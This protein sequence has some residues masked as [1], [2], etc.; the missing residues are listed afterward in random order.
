MKRGSKCGKWK[1][2]EESQRWGRGLNTGS[3]VC[4]LDFLSICCRMVLEI[5]D[6]PNTSESGEAEDIRELT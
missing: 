3:V 6:I 5:F 4:I 1:P 2:V